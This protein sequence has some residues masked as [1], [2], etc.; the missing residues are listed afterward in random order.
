MANSTQDVGT[1]TDL[2]KD[3]KKSGEFNVTSDYKFDGE[4]DGDYTNGTKIK[5]Q[6]LVINGNGK[7]A[8]K[9]TDSNGYITLAFKKITSK[10]TIKITNP[11]TGEISTK[12]ITVASRFSQAKNVK[13]Y[14]N[15]GT[16]YMFIL[17]DD[18]LKK[19]LEKSR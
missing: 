12:T 3:I 15:D 2:D 14:Y 7:S 6:N 19:P 4:N 11:K 1:F 13:M 16:A 17:M 10:Q 5:N 8:T 18:S 9:K